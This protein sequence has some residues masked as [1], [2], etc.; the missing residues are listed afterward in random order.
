MYELAGQWRN[1]RPFKELPYYL[2]T[3]DYAAEI[4]GDGAV[5]VGGAK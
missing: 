2:A 5:V 3:L 4:D 1:F